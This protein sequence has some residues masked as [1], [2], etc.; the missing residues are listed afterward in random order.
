M[1]QTRHSYRVE[2]N[3]VS[4]DVYVEGDGPGLVVLPSYGRGVGEDYDSFAAKVSAAGFKVLRP[5]PRGIAG[6]KGKMNGISLH[7]QADDVALVIRQLS[8]GRAFVLGHAFGHGVA[9]T[10]AADHP[11]LV[12]GVILAA[13]QCSAVPPEISQ[14]PH[15]ACN[16]SAPTEERLAALRKG[17]LAPDH[18]ASIWL[19]GW[20]PETMRMQVSSVSRTSVNEFL[21]AGTAPL[22]EII[23]DSDPFKPREYWGELRQQLGSR[24][25][26][27]VVSDASHALFSEQPERV[28]VAVVEWWRGLISSVVA[29]HAATN[30]N[31]GLFEKRS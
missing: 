16:L 4:L 5:E 12:S 24:V 7:D 14:T 2:G 29:A 17:F 20:Y 18:D 31:E 13:A 21:A 15:L 26:T 27:V 19:D 30:D 10:V 23:P 8:D 1:R 6:S 25:S 22:L 3:D 28:A 9:K 11:A